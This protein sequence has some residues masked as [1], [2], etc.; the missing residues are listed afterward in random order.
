MVLFLVRETSCSRFS[1][2]EKSLICVLVLRRRI[3]VFGFC[4]PENDLKCSCQML[5]KCDPG[6][7]QNIM[8]YD[9]GSGSTT[10][11]IVTYQTVKTKEAGTQPQLQIRGVGWVFDCWH[12]D[13]CLFIKQRWDRLFLLL[14]STVG[15]GA[16]RWTC[17]CGTTWPNF[18]TSRRR[19]RK[20]W[21][22]TTGPWRSSSKRHKDWRLC[23]VQTWTS[24]PRS[25]QRP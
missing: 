14:G 3:W 9:M 16:L 13:R 20:T 2:R 15:W 8:F 23:W 19:V 18:S 4:W 10:A 5:S 21:G 12:A 17:D 22:R 25:A 7:F 11:T 6:L 24:W 1:S